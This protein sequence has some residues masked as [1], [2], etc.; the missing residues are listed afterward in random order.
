MKKLLS[1]LFALISFA[2]FGQTVRAIQGYNPTTMQPGVI[3]R[4][5]SIS[6]PYTANKYITGFATVGSLPDTTRSY[7][8]GTT[9]RIFYNSTTGVFDISNLYIGQ[10]SLTTL[11]TIG[12]GVWNGT[13]ISSIYGGTGQTTYTTGDLLY[14]SATNILS[15]LPIGSTGQGLTVVG[16]I[17]V[18]A[19]SSG[20]GSVAGNNSWVQYNN[21]GAFGADSAFRWKI[22][23]ANTTQNSKVYSG[24]YLIPTPTAQ[25]NN[26]TLVTL[27]LTSKYSDNGLV[28]IKKYDI[29]LGVN[30]I[31]L[32]S[33]YNYSI[34]DGSSAQTSAGYTNFFGYQ[35][36]IYA[37]AA[38]NSNFFGF[39]AG[40]NAVNAFNSNFF[41]SQTG[42]GATNANNSNFFGNLAGYNASGSSSSNFFGNQAGYGANNAPS[43]NFFG[44]QTGANANN[45][46][47]SNF[48]GSQTGNGA[49]NANNSNFFGN[50]A[51]G[52]SSGANNSNFFGNGAGSTSTSASNSNFFGLNSGS[53]ATNA[54]NSNFFGRQAGLYAAN[55]TYSNFFGTNAGL[56][57]TGATYSNFFGT[58]AGLNATGASYSNFFGFQTGDSLTFKITGTNNII[59]GTNIT[60]PTASSNNTMNLGG[61]LFGTNT[62]S[63]ITGNP[64]AIAQTTGQIGINITTPAASAALDITSTIAGFLPP[65]MTATQASAITSPAEGLM[66]YVTNTSATFTAK[67]WWGYDGAAW[68]KLN[69]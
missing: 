6:L 40:S 24:L 49:T 18:W 63:T 36:G 13:S 35:A 52:G 34:S 17:P 44:Y 47:N 54:N 15:K 61:I 8:S 68:Q 32:D 41:G 1:I 65:R 45:A 30:Y 46:S 10:T 19:T 20:G 37:T 11:G 51:G 23:G 50:Y 16:G 69:N 59:I 58:N 9:N 64:S 43:S 53:Q 31:K 2:S 28:G 22:T 55:A 66:V 33:L 4:D 26:D 67:G 39:N 25:A 62:Y 21:A 3:Y 48:F 5:T 56:N 27:N 60:T 42:N 14:A 12:T 57:A 7:F 29:K 38:N